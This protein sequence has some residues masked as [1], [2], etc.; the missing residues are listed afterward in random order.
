M[1]NYLQEYGAMDSFP[2]LVD[3]YTRNDNYRKAEAGLRESEL[4]GKSLLNGFPVTVHGVHKLRHLVNSVGRPLQIRANAIDDSL[5]HR[6][7]E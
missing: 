2:V 6:Q 1:H 3:S 5:I 4:T 7:K